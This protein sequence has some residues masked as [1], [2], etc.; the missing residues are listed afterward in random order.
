MPSQ[1]LAPDADVLSAVA[2]DKTGKYLATGDKGGRIVLL[3]ADPVAGRTKPGGI[4]YKFHVE[5]QS[6]EP[7]FDYVRSTAIEERIAKIRFL[8]QT[9][10]SLYLLSTNDRAI[11]LWYVC[12]CVKTE[13]R[14]LTRNVKTKANTSTGL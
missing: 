11:K 14:I 3:E 9:N 2:F 4:H 13:Q 7:E 1:G 12:V 8:G 6:H 5:F 10:D